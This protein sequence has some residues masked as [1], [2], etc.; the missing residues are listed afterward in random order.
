MPAE[1]AQTQN[2]LANA[3]AELGTR[4]SGA[5]GRAMLDHAVAAY[6]AVLEIHTRA[7]MPPDWAMTQSN[8]GTVLAE[9][10][11]RTGG[12]DGA[13]LLDRAVANWE[14][15]LEV[16]TR[17]T[18]PVQWAMTW[19]NVARARLH[20]SRL[21]ESR[22]APHLARARAAVELALEVFDPLDMGHYHEQA[23]SLR[24][25]IRAEIAGG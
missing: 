25:R 5:S 16:Y 14:A 15:A 1:W 12:D 6:A 4:T 17:E 3:L 7:T 20:M 22:R 13:A 23:T 8:L 18:M 21:D 19:E 9:Q 11:R 10:G 24:D 2:G